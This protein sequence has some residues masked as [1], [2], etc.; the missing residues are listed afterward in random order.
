MGDEDNTKVRNRVSF[1]FGY[2]YLQ[3]SVVKNSTL[4]LKGGFIDV[5][6][7]SVY[8]MKEGFYGSSMVG[9]RHYTHENKQ[10]IS[11]ISSTLIK[12][13]SI[14]TQ[15]FF[16]KPGLDY[17]FY[18]GSPYYWEGGF[19]VGADRYFNDYFTL[20]LLYEMNYSFLLDQKNTDTKGL[21]QKLI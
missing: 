9:T 5:S 18:Q 11:F 17:L 20:L 6:F 15:A 3:D 1:G 14:L 10:L 21:S 19:V 16:I 12:E 8:S 2:N 4:G 13:F 7:D